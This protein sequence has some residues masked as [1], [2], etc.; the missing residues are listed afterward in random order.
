MS[1]ATIFEQLDGV[2]DILA[3]VVG[4][5]DGDLYTGK[6]AQRIVCAA[7]DA[8]R[9][10]VTL[11]TL[12]M[13]RVDQTDAWKN[14]GARSPE[15]WLANKIGTTMSDARGTVEF[16]AQ[17]DALPAVTAAV[18]KGQLSPGK[19]R[20]VAG[21]ASH[22][23]DSEQQL[24]ELAKTGSMMALKSGCAAARQRGVGDD[25]AARIHARRSHRSWIDE[26]GAFR[27]QGVMPVEM[28]AKFKAALDGFTD[29]VFQDARRAG[30]REPYEAYAAD[31]VIRMAEA[32]TAN[33][34]PQDPDAPAAP[35]A[36]KYTASRVHLVIHVD[37]AAWERGY[38]C[39]GETCEV[40][41]VGP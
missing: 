35:A 37:A 17:L 5:F 7:A 26:E 14:D 34:N 31:A 25:A 19:A 13:R 9:L 38:T 12:A 1:G 39:P 2:N 11:K 30:V 22:D 41:G 6:Q 40:A 24:L 16:G 20:M 10:A 18:K 32:A 36:P 21:A 29:Q 15:S 3:A 8:E 27:Y 33:T 28:G 23:P 4:D